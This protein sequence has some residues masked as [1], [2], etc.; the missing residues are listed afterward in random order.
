ME[1]RPP[2]ASSSSAPKTLGESKWGK[3]YQSMEPAAL[4]SATVRM[5]PMIP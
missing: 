4:T 5:L 3:Q 2:F 1:N